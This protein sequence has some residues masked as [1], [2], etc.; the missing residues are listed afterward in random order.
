MP[1]PA[2]VSVTSHKGNLIGQ[3]DHNMTTVQLFIRQGKRT[4]LLTACYINGSKPLA[5]CSCR[6]GP[7]HCP[8]GLEGKETSCSMLLLLVFAVLWNKLSFS[9][10]LNLVVYFQHLWSV[11]SQLRV[12]LLLPSSMR[13][14]FFHDTVSYFPLAMRS[15]QAQACH[16]TIPDSHLW[17]SV[18]NDHFPYNYSISQCCQENQLL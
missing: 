4:G 9:D 15:S 17:G 7:L 13:L 14:G 1:W 10:P 16:I 18:S 2:V 5:Q 12:L 11:A 6:L 8:M 3:G